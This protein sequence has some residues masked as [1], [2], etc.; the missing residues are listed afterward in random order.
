LQ[1][2]EIDIAKVIT[3]TVAIIGQQAERGKLRLTLD[4]AQPLPSVRADSRRLRQILLNLISNSIKFTPEGG[5][6]KISALGDSEGVV[7]IVADTGI[8]M[9]ADDIPKALTRFGQIDSRLSRKYDG[10]GLGLPLSK[11]L[12]ELHGG[13]LEIESVVGHGTTVT[14]RLPRERVMN[15]LRVA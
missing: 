10:T 2:D 7:L 1:D 12:A 4:L 11:R 15:I 5:E 8:G 13:S 9:S 3:D 14:V 6:V